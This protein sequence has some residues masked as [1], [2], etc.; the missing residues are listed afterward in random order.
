MEFNTF[1]IVGR[2]E[3]TGQLGVAV[4][5]AAPAVGAYCPF[6]R[7]GVGAVS[8]QSWCNP[9]LAYDGLDLM[10]QGLSAQ[11]ACD[12]LLE[13]DPGR[14]TRQIGYVDANGGS[15]AFTGKE[16]PDWNGHI[17]GTNFATQGNLLMGSGCVSEMAETFEKAEQL[18]L[19]ER[20]IA[21]LE[22]GQAAGGDA[23]GKQSA[24]VL[25][26]HKERY[27]LVDLR[28]DEHR[29]PVADLRRI[30]GISKLQGLP[31]IAQMP[32]RDNPLGGFAEDMQF[33]MSIGPS[34]RPGGG[35]GKIG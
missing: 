1:S 22:A 21:A 19:V 35:G 3:R 29:F 18:D 26:V 17:T 2:C 23:R 5:T 14:E 31:F 27:P 20:L 6:A 8:S 25:V 32:T 11:E 4:S 34:L 12:K 9:Y 24:A 7:A 15:A 13:E 16:C 33:S 30:Y 28:S 10:E